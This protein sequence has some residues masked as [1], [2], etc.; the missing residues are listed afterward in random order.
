M[1]LYAVIMSDIYKCSVMRVLT[2]K[3]AAYVLLCNLLWLGLVLGSW[4][5]SSGVRVG[6]G[7]MAGGFIRGESN[8]MLGNVVSIFSVIACVSL[9]VFYVT[10][11]GLGR[12]L[13]SRCGS[14]GV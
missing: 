12:V 4:C 5:A 14:S 10:C 2:F 9:H 7:V 13:A 1:K 6:G 11:F 3:V 8:I